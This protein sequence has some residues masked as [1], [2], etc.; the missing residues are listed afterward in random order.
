MAATLSRLLLPGQCLQVQRRLERRKLAENAHQIQAVVILNS[1]SADRVQLA[2]QLVVA[3]D[4][5]V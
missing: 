1:R 2:E 3:R 5:E 4:A